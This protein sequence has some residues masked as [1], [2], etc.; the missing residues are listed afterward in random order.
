MK[1]I[2]YILSFF[3][4]TSKSYA[5]IS[6]NIDC[7]KLVNQLGGLNKVDILWLDDLNKKKYQYALIN[8]SKK[9]I[10]KKYYLCS[11]KYKINTSSDETLTVLSERNLK[12]MSYDP[13]K[14][15]TEIFSITSKEKRNY[16]MQRLNLKDFSMTK[17]QLNQ[18]YIAGL[19]ELNKKL[20]PKVDKDVKVVKKTS[21]A[22]NNISN[23]DKNKTIQKI[24]QLGKSDYYIFGHSTTGQNFWG[25][26][27]AIN[28]KVQAGKAFSSNGITCYIRSEQK[29]NVAPFKGSFTLKCPNERV[30]GSWTQKNTYSPG[31]GQGF[32]ESG[33]VV[34]AFFSFDKSIILDSANNFFDKQTIKIAKKNEPSQSEITQTFSNDITPP[35]III[36]K[37]LTFKNSAYK[38]EGEVKDEGSK[39]I[40]VEIDGVI[41]R[42][43]NG[44]FVFERFSPI[45]ERV[46]IV[47]IDQWGNRSKEKIVNI[48][49]AT[50][51]KIVKKKLDKLNPNNKKYNNITKDKVAI[52]I[53]IEKYD[54]TPN[55]TYA[56]LDAKYFYEYA[57][58]SF[59]I[60][61]ENIKLLV[62]KDANYIDTLGV[63]EKWLPG[64]ITKNRTELIIF[65]AGHGLA[66][67]DGKELYL[68]PQNSDP[69]LLERTA[70]SRSELFNTILEFKPKRVTMFFDTCYSGTSRD[71][72]S[73]LASARPLRLVTNIENNIPENF[74]IFSA[75][76]LDQISSGLKQ[77]S[78]GIFSYYLM[79]GLEGFA[80]LNKDKKITNGELLAYMDQN[81]S[82]K[83]SELGRKQ[84][85]SLSG[86]PNKVL[87]SYK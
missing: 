49:I 72:E 19:M 44:K 39:N 66:S 76:K 53:G 64:K 7:A 16:I 11:N 33:D 29:N 26:T 21:K 22:D 8:L 78:H 56:N 79:K 54:R 14:I 31:I 37:N 41:Q 4:L 9:N 23:K 27:D 83:A 48:K 55:A 24:N 45:N 20:N 60:P 59:G 73:L 34:T 52:V 69:D 82:Q 70:L 32:T 3:I 6:L 77:A 36:P 71:E 75:S 10:E 30:D 42:A 62:D 40:Y 86:D 2:L 58:L 51:T 17:N 25:S 28:N 12:S 57:R 47:A 50:E 68:L 80:D 35:K 81:V 67:S 87:I 43:K 18:A 38:L 15:F 5:S 84:N 63:L 46:K 13:V 74:T 65:F 85:P 61:T 1:K